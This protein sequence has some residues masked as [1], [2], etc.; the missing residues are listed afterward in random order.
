MIAIIIANFGGVVKGRNG[1]S[2]DM[3]ESWGLRDD[4]EALTVAMEK[5]GYIVEW[6]AVEK[7]RT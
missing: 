5:L 6:L 7:Y 1:G 2:E 3:D 4:Y